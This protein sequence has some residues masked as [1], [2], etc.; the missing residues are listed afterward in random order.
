M[1]RCIFHFII[2][3]F[4]LKK[5]IRFGKESLHIALGVDALDSSYVGTKCE[6]G[7]KD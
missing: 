4:S 6:C 7:G 5:I 3:H 1:V 2:F